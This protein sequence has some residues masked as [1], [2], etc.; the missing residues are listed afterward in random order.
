MHKTH[1][2]K[3]F[4][5]LGTSSLS[6]IY[7]VWKQ[8]G[9]RNWLGLCTTHGAHYGPFPPQ[10]GM[11]QCNTANRV[12]SKWPDNTYRS[13][14]AKGDLQNRNY[15][16]VCVGDR[17][18]TCQGSLITW[19]RLGPNIRVN[20]WSP[21]SPTDFNGSRSIASSSLTFVYLFFPITLDNHL[22][23]HTAK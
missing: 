6:N 8:P 22:I 15:T 1:R 3:S 10:N 12:R 4:S 16:W 13:N 11:P 5:Y 23:S 19:W 18:V 21:S 7:T 17:N 9:Q 2:T 20:Q 14:M